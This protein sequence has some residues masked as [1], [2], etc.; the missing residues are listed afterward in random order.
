[1]HQAVLVEPDCQATI[2]KDD[3]PAHITRSLR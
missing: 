1:V 3:W 2:A